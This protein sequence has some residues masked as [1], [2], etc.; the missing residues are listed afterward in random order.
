MLRDQSRNR[1]QF[2][3]E[4]CFF[5]ENGFVR[6]KVRTKPF[7]PLC[8]ISCWNH[9]PKCPCPMPN[10]CSKFAFCLVFI[11]MRTLARGRFMD[12]SR[13]LNFLSEDG[14]ELQIHTTPPDRSIRVSL[15]LSSQY[16]RGGGWG[17]E[18]A[19]Q[20]KDNIYSCMSLSGA[21]GEI[22]MLVDNS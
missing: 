7:L 8:L 13:Y 10:V 11:K 4:H 19:S 2:C 16:F 20:P 12:T 15:H 22:K 9:A 3:A 6:I 1:D 14:S 18:D 5:R 17:T 21:G